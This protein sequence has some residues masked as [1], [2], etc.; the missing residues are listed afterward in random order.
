MSFLIRNFPHTAKE[1]LDN[2]LLLKLKTVQ[3]CP[4]KALE[5]YIR[6]LEGQKNIKVHIVWNIS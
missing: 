4:G 3:G 1:S 5:D 6:K 2:L